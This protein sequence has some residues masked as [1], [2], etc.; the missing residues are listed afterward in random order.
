MQYLLNKY[1]QLKDDPRF[2]QIVAD[3]EGFYF[4]HLKELIISLFCL[5]NDY[6]EVITRLRTL[7]IESEEEYMQK[8]EKKSGKSKDIDGT[9]SC[10][11]DDEDDDEDDEDD[12]DD[13]E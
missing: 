6:N 1:P 3:T 8:K 4:S 9:V 11:D 2:D 5:D 12:E 13:D 10:S 7:I